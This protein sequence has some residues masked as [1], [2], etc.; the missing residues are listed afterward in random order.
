[1]SKYPVKLVSL[2]RVPGPIVPQEPQ[3]VPHTYNIER[4]Q[5]ATSPGWRK[6][7]WMSLKAGEVV[8]WVKDYLRARKLIKAWIKIYP[9]LDQY[10]IQP[11]ARNI[12]DLVAIDFSAGDLL[13]EI[14][15]HQYAVRQL[16]S[17]N[18]D[19]IIVGRDIMDKLYKAPDFYGSYQVADYHTGVQRAIREEYNVP[20]LMGMRVIFMPYAEGLVIFDSKL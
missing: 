17:G 2:K 14:Y 10:S 4:L 20:T 15:N 19:T 18:P 7:F 8:K 16:T 9:Y 3:E 6:P 1:M 12:D 5:K 11:P 13:K